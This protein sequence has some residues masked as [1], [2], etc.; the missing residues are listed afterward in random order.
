MS[1]STPDQE[2]FS[3]QLRVDR[4]EAEDPKGVRYSP[5]EF[6]LDLAVVGQLVFLQ[7]VSVEEDHKSTT[8]THAGEG[9]C[10]D[11]RALVMAL[12]AQSPIEFALLV[13]EA[14]A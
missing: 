10:V 12:A 11:L 14:R 4:Q 3:V 2:T 8:L 1:T 6:L 9:M 13:K 7:R 5:P